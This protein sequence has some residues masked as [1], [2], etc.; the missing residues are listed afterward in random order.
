[1]YSNANGFTVSGKNKFPTGSDSLNIIMVRLQKRNPVSQTGKPGSR[2]GNSIKV[3]R[4]LYSFPATRV[5]TAMF[6]SCD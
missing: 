3:I 4:Y 5:K 2:D 6:R 1:M